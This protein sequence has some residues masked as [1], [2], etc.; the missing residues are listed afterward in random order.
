MFVVVVTACP[1]I[2][3]MLHV[4]FHI[5]MSTHGLAI[6]SMSRSE[7]VDAS[8]TACTDL[9]AHLFIHKWVHVLV[10]A[11]QGRTRWLALGEVWEASRLNKLLLCCLVGSHTLVICLVLLSLWVGP[12]P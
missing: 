1:D 7:L 9:M 12:C 10:H 2:L 8:R 3:L 6:S 11:Y 4:D 5:F